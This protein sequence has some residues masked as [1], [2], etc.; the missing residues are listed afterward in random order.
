V[1]RPDRLKVYIEPVSHT[2]K[3]LIIKNIDGEITDEKITD[4]VFILFIIIGLSSTIEIYAAYTN[5][6]DE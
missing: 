5:I 4:L 2:P 6:I 3:L 1:I